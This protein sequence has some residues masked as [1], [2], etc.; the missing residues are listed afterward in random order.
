[1][2]KLFSFLLSFALLLALSAAD[3]RAEDVWPDDISIE[4]GGGIVMEASTGTILS[5]K[6]IHETFYPA[7]ITKILTALIVLET[8]ELDETVT[9]SHDAIYNVESGSTSAGLDVGDTLSVQDCLY[10]L[11]LKSANEVANALA[12]HVA[13]SIDDFAVLMNQKA[14]SLGCVDSHFANPS[15]LNNADHYTSAYD[16]ALISQAAL[17][18]PVF[19]EIDSR[20]YYDLPPTKRNPDG[21]RVYP[22]HRM[23]KKNLAEYYEGCFGGKTGYT[24]LAGNTLVTF[25]KRDNMTLIAVVLNGHQSHYRDT[26]KLL[27]FGFDHFQNLAAAEFDHTY[28]SIENDMTIAGLP[29]SELSRLQL[30]PAGMLT[31]PVSGDS[32][33]VTS[34]LNYD[35]PNNAPPG[36]I[37][38]VDYAWG[39]RSAGFAYLTINTLEPDAAAMP[40]SLL[41]QIADITAA[42]SSEAEESAPSSEP[43][44]LERIQVPSIVWKVL[45]TA[46]AIAG[47]TALLAAYITYRKRKEE[48][49]RRLRRQKR[50][51]RLG[52]GSTSLEFDLQMERRRREMQEGR[53]RQPFQR[54]TQ[55]RRNAAQ[56][57]ANRRRRN[58]YRDR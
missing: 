57:N 53:A 43:P 2:K 44:E 46:A 29:T 24:T 56:R 39:G 32:S 6:N 28:T 38:R 3:V 18:N 1:M 50:M 23:F 36:A 58:T 40:A 48:E 4:A 15:G 33:T 27:D 30:D 8:C 41:R 25:A 45:G 21:L 22:G 31:L 10:A 7:S 19:V 52:T 17:Q 42:E 26:K 54:S 14:A 47:I 13:G 35:L 51:E 49:A 16:M 37:A 5:G 11:L 9:F 20:L 12:E 55:A 34:Q